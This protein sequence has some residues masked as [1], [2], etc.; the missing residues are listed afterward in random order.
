MSL[1]ERVSSD[2]KSSHIHVR[3]GSPARTVRTLSELDDIQPVW[4]SYSEL[5][6][7]ASPVQHHVWARTYAEVYGAD[8]R[9]E[10]I[11]AG[12]GRAIG[13]APLFRPRGRGRRLELIGVRELYEV[14]DFLY[15]DSSDIEALA[16]AI[17]ATRLPIVL[18]RMRQD[19]RALAALKTAY[20]GNAILFCRPARGCPWIA[21]DDSWV[22]PEQH[23][24]S[25]RRSD[26]RRMR[27][28]AEK[29]GPVTC[30]I[31]SPTREELPPLLDEA[32]RVEAAGWKGHNR[33]ALLSDPSLG[34]FYRLYAAAAAECGI[35][36]LSFLRIGGEAAAMQL[37]VVT[38]N[39][40]WLFKIGY[41][42]KCA[43]C[44]PGILL[45]LETIRFAAQA[46]LRSYEFLGA[47][48][49][50]L[51]NWTSLEHP[52]VS[53]RAYPANPRGI[54]ALAADGV[55]ASVRKVRSG[56]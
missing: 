37:G 32:Y 5:V 26:L 22:N 53:F 42:E 13:I 18:R 30:E 3:S 10:V 51:R 29:I 34:E 11:M 44:S 48:E 38:G 25:G 7:W 17:A 54:A 20:R 36:R 52:C 2:S 50:W 49:P 45:M 27:R 6:D 14:M 41:S 46:R 31:L 8:S 35:L 28:N 33:T 40:F 21:L 47:A 39:R 15:S 19:S 24:N 4:D 43:R 16:S 23:V 1:L 9:L 12:A 55:A 56:D